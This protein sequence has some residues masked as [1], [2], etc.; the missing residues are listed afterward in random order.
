[1]LEG[2]KLK[3]MI[4]VSLFI[5]V[6]LIASVI[7]LLLQKPPGEEEEI[8]EEVSL[9]GVEEVE[10]ADYFMAIVKEA[11]EYKGAPQYE[12]PLDIGKISNIVQFKDMLKEKALEYLRM[13][14]FVVIPGKIKDV[15]K[16]YVILG[17]KEVPLYITVDSVLYAYHVLFLSFLAELE[18][19]KL[20]P[21]LLNLTEALFKANL[22]LY[23]DVKNRDVDFLL[24]EAIRRD[25]AYFSVVLKLLKED[26][27]VPSEVKNMVER[28]LTLIYEAKE[29]E[30]YSPI[31]CYEEDYTQYRPRGH[32]VMSDILS[33]YFRAMMYLGRMR[34]SAFSFNQTL[35][36]LQTLQALIICYLLLSTDVGNAKALDIWL[37]IYL[38]TTFLVG[39]SDDLTPL[40]Y[41]IFMKNVYG[42]KVELLELADRSKLREIEKLAIENNRSRIVNV[43]IFPWERKEIIGMRFMGQRF[44]LDG[45]V[46]QELC[47]PKVEG[48]TMVK[49]LDVMAA[50]G[51]NRA[52]E[53]LKDEYKYPGYKEQMTKLREFIASLRVANWSQSIYS[54]WLYTIKSLLSQ[55][56]PYEPT[57][58]RTMA[59]IDKKLYTALASWAHLRHDT[60]LYAKQPYALKIAIPPTPPD[61]GYVE[62]LPELYL[63]LKKLTVMMRE[64]LRSLNLLEKSWEK[65]LRKLE[66]VLDKL[67]VIAEKELNSEELSREEKLFIRNY[68]LHL[69]S[70][71]HGLKRVFIDPRIIADVFTDPNTNRVLEVG[72]GYFDTIFVVYAK[73]NGELYVAQGFT[74]SFYEFTWPQTRRLTDQEWRELL[75]KGGIERPFWTTSFMVQE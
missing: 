18:E 64:G 72:T 61:V 34:F 53:L 73:P 20:C 28:E 35:A 12:L 4:I 48:R 59:Y 55:P 58:M 43:P 54:Y 66:A 45:Y 74:L 69:E 5:A 27:E 23:E 49:A 39:F 2:D 52:L 42:N 30:A 16:A 36:D 44:I 15:A 63:R 25:L 37:R 22:E 33:R 32:Y 24:K 14:G 68:G 31:F 17:D 7:S 50:L 29:V 8:V 13:N 9:E 38:P 60:I 75:E 19:K 11:K 56:K 26:F 70:I 51:S 65:R 3:K 71:F 47:Y 57:F 46:H 1:M 40:D 6:I 62:P 21:L 67:R 41:L 10:L